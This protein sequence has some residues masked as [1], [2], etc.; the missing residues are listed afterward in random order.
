[1]P[2]GALSDV[3]VLEL[4]TGVAG[5][6]CG[7]LLSDLGAQVVKVEPPDGDPCRDEAPI[8]HGESA[9][10]VWLN[11]GKRNVSLPIG[12]A[13]LE[14]L[15]AHADIII[16]SELGAPPDALEARLRACSPSAAIVSLSPYG[17]SGERSTWQTTPIT[18]YAT[19][20]Y[21]YIA[22]DPDRE[23][24]ALPGHHVEFHA[25]MHAAAGVLAGLRH[26]RRSGQ[27]QLIEL[28]HQEAM[29]RQRLGR[30]KGMSNVVRAARLPSAPTV[31]SS[32]SG[33]RRR[34]TSSS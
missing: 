8:V 14:S 24:L 18:E 4:A 17:R 11:A 31:T 21:H 9:F 16:H 30:T 5:P 32:S 10:Y 29:L 28:S 6:Y 25:G 27:G 7:R 33:W 34:R 12:D 1:M 23:P 22:G 2:E 20:G 19:S 3:V 15:A 13:R 26:A